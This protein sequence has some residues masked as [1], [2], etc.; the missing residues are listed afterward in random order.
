MERTD[1]ECNLNLAISDS[2][3]RAHKLRTVFKALPSHYDVHFK[4][5]FIFINM[6]LSKTVSMLF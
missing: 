2:C 5:K 4:Y 1:V 6:Y 3:A